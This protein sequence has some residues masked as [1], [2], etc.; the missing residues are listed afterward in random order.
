VGRFVNPFSSFANAIGS[1][2]AKGS[3][4]FFQTPD[5]TIFVPIF[6]DPALSNQINNPVILDGNGV[7]ESDVFFSGTI[8]CVLKDSK[9][10]IIRAV[11][12]VETF[13]P[14]AVLAYNNIVTYSINNLVQDD[15]DNEYYVSI[16]NNNTG[17]QPS[18]SP[19]LWAKLKWVE[20]YNTNQTYAAGDIV[21]ASDNKAYISQLASNT[22]NDPVTDD[23]TNWLELGGS[24]IAVGTGAV[25]R[26][27]ENKLQSIPSAGDYDLTGDGVTSDNSKLQNLINN[28][29]PFGGE[30]YLENPSVSY[31]IGGLVIPS[32]TVLDGRGSV[33]LKL[34][35]GV[36]TF[37][38]QGDNIEIKNFIL[39][40][41]SSAGNV[42]NIDSTVNRDTIKI[43]DC[44]LINPGRVLTDSNDVGN[45]TNLSF[46]NI[47]NTQNKG[48]G[49][50]LRD[51]TS[52][53]RLDNIRLDYTGATV[54]TNAK[55]FEIRNATQGYVSN[56][57]VKGLP[58]A[59]ASHEAFFFDNVQNFDFVNLIADNMANETFVLNSLLNCSFTGC[60]ATECNLTGFLLTACVGLTFSNCIS[61]AIAALIS[62]SQ[63]GFDIDNT[64]NL[65][66]VSNCGLSEWDSANSA[67]INNRA[68]NV[69]IANSTFLFNTIDIEGSDL[70]AFISIGNRLN[71][72][73]R[74]PKSGA[75]ES[76]HIFNCVNFNN[77][78]LGQGVLVQEK[79]FTNVATVDFSLLTQYFIHVFQLINVVAL[80][81]DTAITTRISI[82]GGS[83]FINSASAYNW[84][85][86][87]HNAGN[88]DTS[89]GD[90][91]DAR[92]RMNTSGGTLGIGNAPAED[93]V[94]GYIVVYS[95]ASTTQRKNI[96]WDLSY[97]DSI[98][99]QSDVSGSGRYQLGDDDLTDIRFL[100]LAGNTSGIIRYLGSIR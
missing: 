71:S 15:L 97:T 75:T 14:A 35:S 61:S 46:Y 69:Q 89:S 8:R 19:T 60:E 37:L 87:G 65:I 5:T 59:P 81:D 23:G 21:V 45:I 41:S 57:Y 43:H 79:E 34:S 70:S 82:D 7:L 94:S 47:T 12:N 99:Q 100:M 53:L 25:E 10:N 49:V 90:I 62:T 40:A 44:I 91:A 93:G 11:N 56:L 16:G 4:S 58:T 67:G 52:G 55:G 88:V 6:S 83:T 50:L 3:I 77:T 51:A 28:S 29:Q 48:D 27:V 73:T 86:R 39:D 36:T 63:S 31:L 85:N 92:L 68:P 30:I 9:G 64:C 95:P 78:P 66:T 72:I 20:D 84:V 18:T 13:L 42:F 74:T 24:F 96:K 1:A 98:S 22:G 76:D 38:I 2:F 33:I 32:N 26:T 80:S 54:G 17:N